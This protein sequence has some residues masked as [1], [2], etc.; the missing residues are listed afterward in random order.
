MEVH[1]MSSVCI[2]FRELAEK[3]DLPKIHLVH[4]VHVG[5]QEVYLEN[6]LIGSDSYLE[7]VYDVEK[8]N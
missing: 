4:E 7:I 8:S 1:P 5:D 3:L 6:C 2:T